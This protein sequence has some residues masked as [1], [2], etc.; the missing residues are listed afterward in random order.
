MLATAHGERT[1]TELDYVR[2]SKF[3][4][5]P[6]PAALSDLLDTADILPSREMPS[7]IVTMYTQVEIEDLPGGQRQKIRI[8]YPADANP[9]TGYISVFS[10][11]GIGLLGQKTGAVARWKTPDGGDHSARVIAVLFQAEARGDY[12]T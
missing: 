9:T 1:L 5:A 4:D 7:D 8:C 12:T 6:L 11:V 2:L 3:A 10:P